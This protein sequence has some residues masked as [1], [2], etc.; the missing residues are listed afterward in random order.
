MA[1]NRKQEKAFAEYTDIH[2][3]GTNNF[4]ERIR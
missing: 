1:K 3:F 2:F 4:F